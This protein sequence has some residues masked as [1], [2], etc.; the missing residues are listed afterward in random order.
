[1]HRFSW[2]A[3]VALWAAPAAAAFGIGRFSAPATPPRAPVD[4]AGAIRAALGAGDVLEPVA[5]TTSLLERLDPTQLPDV[6]AVYER[7][8]PMLG[9]WELSFVF[10]AWAGF[11]PA[12]ALEHALAWPMRGMQEE[13]RVGVRAVLETWA[14]V[15]SASARQAAEAL[16]AAHPRLRAD[17]WNS[18]V[19]G[20][21]R[22]DG[23][24]EGLD[25]FLAAL[26]PLRQQDE[27]AGIALR[28][29]VRAG[30]AEAALAWADT[31]LQNDSQEPVFKRSVFDSAVRWAAGWDPERTGEW[32][33][34]HA[35]AA[36]AEAGPVLV[37]ESWG[38]VDGAAAMGWLEAQP[39]GE[40]RD[41]AVRTAFLE[42]IRADRAGA[43]AWLLA[44]SP[45]A[46]HDPALE[47][48]A[49]KL[50]AQEPAEAVAW[51]ERILDP[52]RR[53]RCLETTARGWYMR[54]AMAAEVWLQHSPLDDETRAKVRR[55]VKQSTQGTRR[56]RG[57]R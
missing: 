16:A 52:A 19:T 9:P 51:C 13:R 49:E 25:A 55:P 53:Q 18:L 28:E 24:T 14:P 23:G 57:P 10:S 1:L 27:S 42:W 43:K 44:I 34:G 35:D 3:D 48:W 6:V 17:A 46:F 45:T 22:S 7:M 38:P 40:R 30:G 29:L 32:V 20:W 54:D 5:R 47:S 4:A 56:P 12:G 11:D 33:V 31:I 41:K 36:F 15:D 50:V 2:G 8:I 37:A 39:I 21:V 26:R